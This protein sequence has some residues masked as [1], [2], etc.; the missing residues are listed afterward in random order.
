ME[1]ISKILPGS[2][3][4]GGLGRK[5]REQEIIT[6]FGM[7]ADSFLPADLRHAVRGLYVRS[8]ILT[9][10][11]LSSYATEAL[12]RYQSDVLAYIKLIEPD[13]KISGLRILA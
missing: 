10:A 4:R 6:A 11:S 8:G 12:R 1:S 5:V 7:A 3:R 9:V 13:A 2:L